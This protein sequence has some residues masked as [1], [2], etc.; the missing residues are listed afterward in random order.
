M[1][2]ESRIG[3]MTRSRTAQ[4][5]NIGLTG[6]AAIFL[7]VMAAAAG[8]RAAH[9]AAAVDPNAETLAVLGVAPSSGSAVTLRK[10]SVPVPP[11]VRV[12][13]RI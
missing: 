11:K 3:R 4:R 6:L 5:V 13:E 7:T 12:R 10:S 8:V 2:K 9:P 1:D